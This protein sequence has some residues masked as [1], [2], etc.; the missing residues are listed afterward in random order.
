MSQGR[1]GEGFSL[2]ADIPIDAVRATAA[3]FVLEGRGGDQGDFR[4]ELH[5]DYP[6][7]AKTR[8][9]LGEL[10][11]QAEVRVSRRGAVRAGG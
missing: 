5:F 2:V 3:G 7:D 9:V 10:L 4:L 6:V 11:S 1:T 8:K